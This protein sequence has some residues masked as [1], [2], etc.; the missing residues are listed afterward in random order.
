MYAPSSQF[1]YSS[2]VTLFISRSWFHWEYSLSKASLF[3]SVLSFSKDGAVRLVMSPFIWEISP[4]ISSIFAPRFASSSVISDNLPA[5][6][7]ISAFARA[8]YS[9]LKSDTA[10]C[11]S[12]S[13]SSRLFFS[14]TRSRR[15][16][17]CF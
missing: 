4:R 16:F 5:F 13:L 8:S 7:S 9:C 1:M 10:L 6:A 17:S 15:I 11:S 12:L 3:L 14:F 2:C